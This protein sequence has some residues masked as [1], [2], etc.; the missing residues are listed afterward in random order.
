MSVITTKKVT[1]KIARPYK[2]LGTVDGSEDKIVQLSPC[3]FTILDKYL[4]KNREIPYIETE[5]Y[6]NDP[7]VAVCETWE[8]SKSFLDSLK[9]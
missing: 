2:I 8:E 7:V 6:K 4:S 9:S 5:E 3:C 1:T